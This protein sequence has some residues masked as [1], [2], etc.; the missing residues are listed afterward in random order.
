MPDEMLKKTFAYNMRGNPED[1]NYTFIALLVNNLNYKT[2]T[3][4]LLINVSSIAGL[5]LKLQ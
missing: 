4:I 3:E 5:L 2:I 1:V